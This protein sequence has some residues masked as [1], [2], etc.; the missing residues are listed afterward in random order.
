MKKIVELVV[1]WENMEFDD[2]GVN[3]MSLVDRPAIQLSWQAFA[4]EEF[5]HPE[6]GEKEEEFI[7]RCIPVL[8][9]EGYGDS[10]AA[11]IC[12]NYWNEGKMEECEDCFDLDEACWP[13]YEAIGTKIKDGREVPNCVPIENA[14]FESITDY[15]EGVKDAAARGIRLNEA[16]NNK[17]ATQ[18][19]KV[20]AQQ[21]AQGKPISEETVKRMYSYLSRASAYYDPK[22]TEACGTISYLLWGG[23][24]G[25]KWAKRKLNQLQEDFLLEL[26][27]ERGEEVD[28]ENATVVD[29]TKSEFSTIGDFLKGVTALDILGKRVKKDEEGV[30]K[31][32]YAGPVAERNFCKAMQRLN[33]LYTREEID[34]MSQ[35]VNTGF[36]HNGQSYSIFDFKGGVNCKHYWEE[37]VVFKGDNNQTIMIAKGPARGR[38]GETASASNNYWRFSSEDEM[39]VTGPAMVPNKL[40][41][42]KDQLGNDFHVYFSQDTIGKIAQKYLKEYTHNTDVNHDDNITTENTL[43]E[44]WIVEDPDYD[45]STKLGFDVP[46][47]TW[48]VSYKINDEETWQKIK[49][50]ELNGFSVTGNFLEK[51]QS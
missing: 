12:Y 48:M 19:G 41:L 40:I 24:A 8:K 46:K 43:L 5:V 14:E 2:L 29:I 27:K 45:K 35:R 50:G 17:C 16:V 23:E 51:L 22:D 7:S 28:Y 37:V 31:Y 32:R 3:I 20:R 47:G 11:A 6:A 39:I 49:K 42:R 21:L 36:R 34:D 26:A 4:S 1:D 44:S 13:G 25:L 38:A 18:V 30:T 10:Q 15:P 33:K 9:G